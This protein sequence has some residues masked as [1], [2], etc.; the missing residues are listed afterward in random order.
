[1]L[2]A[3]APT[4]PDLDA[5]LLAARAAA[6]EEASLDGAGIRA[7]LRA[8]G[9]A[10]LFVAGDPLGEE[11]VRRRHAVADAVG[12]SGSFGVAG[13][14]VAH[15]SGL[16][17]LASDG[18]A[19]ACGETTL[20]LAIAGAVPVA[21]AAPDAR[22]E[23]SPVHGGPSVAVSGRLAAVLNA[24]PETVLVARGR[25]GR[26]GERIV[27]VPLTAAG[28]AVTP[29]PT[30]VFRPATLA[31][32]TLDYELSED[33]VWPEASDGDLARRIAAEQRILACRAVVSVMG[34]ALDRTLSFVGRRALGDGRLGDLQAVRH[35]L[36]DLWA[37]HAMHEAHVEAA[38]AALVA[39]DAEVATRGGLA[40]LAV[41]R[42]V[43]RFVERCVQLH[44]ASGYMEDRWAG[45]AFRDSLAVDVILG[46]RETLAE[47]LDD[48][49]GLHAPHSPAP[50]LAGAI[51]P[52]GAESHDRFRRRVRRLVADHLVPRL[53][54]FDRDGT[55]P[56]DVFRRFG[57]EGLAGVVVSPGWG[58][59]GLDFFH[60]VIVAEELAAARALSPAVS[61]LV[62]ANTVCPLL[63]RHATDVV[64]HDWL[65]PM[66]RGTR[67]ASLA[68]TEDASGS[69]LPYNLRTTARAEGGEWVVDG[70][71]VYIT[72]APIADVFLVLA[73]T[74]SES[75]PL[76]L[77]L[78]AVPADVSGVRVVE[79][80][81][82]I[83]L[84]GSPTGRVRFDAVRVPA[85]CLVGRPHF[86][87][88]YF[89]RAMMGERLLIAAGA[90]AL[91]R[92]CVD[93]LDRWLGED[94]MARGDRRRADRLRGEIWELRAEADA[95]RAFVHRAALHA[96][97][98]D[99]AAPDAYA[100]K[101]AVVET[102]QRLIARCVEL[103]GLEALLA[104]G[105]WARASADARVLSVFAGTSEAM[106]D[107]LG[108][109]LV[110]RMRL[111]AAADA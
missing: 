42:S 108:T 6:A 30:P 64:K 60:L 47:W 20:A 95:C 3:P 52:D 90:A 21:W 29:W 11:S 78:L 100:A 15:M 71:K 97:R 104:G 37:V 23:R 16:L 26:V 22:L 39:G 105:E 67:I 68:V 35:T 48:A 13:A 75:G 88:A 28:V 61:L 9:D 31:A 32:V 96:S 83:G 101:S 62:A 51:A 80:H 17:D 92:S 10:G 79:Q 58:G 86:G 55:L 70:E 91:A 107:A 8:C 63:D 36:A 106:R 66:A 109:T 54:D 5:V 45:P 2:I 89:S 19:G 65:A 4:G 27:V 38:Q 49:A 33:H 81:R 98:D 25:G 85:H 103:R 76:G 46:T 99:V 74:A 43:K 41:A 53:D 50:A 93:R 82:K 12:R 59:A 110:P 40:A 102:C 72:N 44:G 1:V 73:R 14:V 84:L 111:A 87:Y 18:G 7:L 57:E 94:D 69:G 24:S 77:S 56:R 34:Q